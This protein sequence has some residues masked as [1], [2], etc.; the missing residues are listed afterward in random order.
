MSSPWLKH[1]LIY[2]LPFAIL[3]LA[4]GIF[5]RSLAIGH[6]ALVTVEPQVLEVAVDPLQFQAV[7][8]HLQLT[9]RTGK[10]IQVR[11][12]ETS[13]SC[14][15]L[16]TRGGHTLVEPLNVPPGSSVPWQVVIHTGGRSG[17]NKFMVFFETESDGRISQTLS[18]IKMNIRPALAIIPSMIE[19]GEVAPGEKRVAT[20]V[21]SDGYSDSGY[22]VSRF[23][24][25]DPERLSVKIT[26]AKRD[27]PTGLANVEGAAHFHARWRIE[28]R[29]LAPMSPHALVQ[30]E[31]ILEPKNNLHPQLS[32]PVTCRMKP[33]LYELYPETLVLT[34]DTLGRTV[35]RT[36]RCRLNGG[37]KPELQV[38]FSPKLAKVRIVQIDTQISELQII[39][40]VPQSTVE[41]SAIEPI[42]IGYGPDLLKAFI[43]PIEFLELN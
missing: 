14:A 3:G 25:S 20:V 12:A 9:N 35:K 18:T 21:L 28:L 17:P 22:N 8:V 38:I 34:K 1:I 39:L 27:T 13:C 23:H 16:V 40:N 24:V 4:L 30:D 36:I 29:Y 41:A 37:A 26:P 32:I 2:L 43:I 7:T 15:S 31:V 11:K 5:F 10:T 6:A 42:V 33:P 19:F